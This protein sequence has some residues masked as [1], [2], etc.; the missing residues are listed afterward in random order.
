MFFA[1]STRKRPPA[2]VA[3]P[4]PPPGQRVA[5]PPTP[6]P[7]MPKPALTEMRGI[8]ISDPRGLDWGRV[9]SDLRGAGF[10]TLFVN[11]N[12]GGAA[13]YPSALL[14]N[15]ATRDEM[16]LC[17]DAARAHGIRVHAKFI[18]WY[19]FKTT[20]PYG[21]RLAKERRLLLN[22]NGRPLFEGDSTWLN[23]AA[24]IN[25][26]ERL[27]QI[28]EALQRYRVDGVQLDY[29]RFPESAGAITS[30]RINVNTQFLVEVRREIQRLRPGLP[31]SVST[32][33]HPDRAR[34]DMGQDWVVWATRRYVDFLCPM[35]YT[36][37][38]SQLH[39]WILNQQELV[40]SRVP[41]Y[42]GIG[43]Y[44]LNSATL[45]NQQISLVRKTN[46][47]GFVV[48]AYND[49]FRKTHLPGL[50]FP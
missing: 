11:F 13:F 41:I 7:D 1:C 39:R 6:T 28:R 14:P 23:P 16:K 12:T 46:P 42:P 3:W 5:P 45:L 18:V 47:S 38:P 40:Q 25:R 8:W 27:A 43:A 19:M 22:D 24:G 37:D 9:M 48:F 21:N 49:Q 10:N 35:D 15:V 33:Y 34:N 17:L 44:M 20:S 32:F 29:I 36:R 50:R 31:L 30:A 26:K 2:D 4:E